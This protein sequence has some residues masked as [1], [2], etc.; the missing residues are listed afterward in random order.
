MELPK[1]FIS[2]HLTA[3]DFKKQKDLPAIKCVKVATHFY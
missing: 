1:P 2:K 3:K